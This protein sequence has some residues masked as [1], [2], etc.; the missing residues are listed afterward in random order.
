MKGLIEEYGILIIE[1]IA[2]A[3]VG[4]IVLGLVFGEGRALPMLLRLIGVCVTGG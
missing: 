4:L 1:A 3:L 2:F